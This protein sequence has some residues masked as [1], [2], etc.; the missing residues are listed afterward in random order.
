MSKFCRSSPNFG[1]LWVSEATLLWGTV[2]VWVTVHYHFLD[3][4]YLINNLS[5][6]FEETIVGRSF[7]RRRFSVLVW[8]V[9]IIIILC[10]CI[11]FFVMVKLC[12]NV[13]DWRHRIHYTGNTFVNG[14]NT[15]FCITEAILL[16][17]TVFPLMV[18]NEN[19]HLL[20]L[21]LY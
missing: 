19:G 15:K 3:E 4:W 21:W 20:P 8:F 7:K 11:Y 10:I 14:R 16:V 17:K 13:F 18:F 6:S 2:Y 1:T 12:L 5:M 9:P